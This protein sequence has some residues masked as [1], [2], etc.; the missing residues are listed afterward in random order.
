[1]VRSPSERLGQTTWDGR[2]R[3]GG[4]ERGR[5][6]EHRKIHPLQ[7]NIID[8]LFTTAATLRAVRD[9]LKFQ[10]LT[11]VPRRVTS[12]KF[13]TMPLASACLIEAA[14]AV[15]AFQFT[16][17]LFSNPGRRTKPALVAAMILSRCMFYPVWRRKLTCGAPS[18][19]TCRAVHHPAAVRIRVFRGEIYL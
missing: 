18:P 13:K 8:P 2:V 1:M 6:N 5:P 17:S 19:M 14:H 12:C 3:G 16:T 7:K 10:W 4:G 15:S 9:S 11:F